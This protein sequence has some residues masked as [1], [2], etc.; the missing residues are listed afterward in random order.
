[1]FEEDSSTP[2]QID[3][4]QQARIPGI[5][6]LAVAALAILIG[7]TNCSPSIED[8]YTAKWRCPRS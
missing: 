4:D 2:T 6:I 1:M 5:L 7:A 3:S 8:S